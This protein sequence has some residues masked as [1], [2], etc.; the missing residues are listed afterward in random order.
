MKTQY[1]SRGRFGA[2][3]RVTFTTAAREL[4]IDRTT[5]W[6]WYQSGKLSRDDAGRIW[7]AE[8]RKLAAARTHKARAQKELDAEMTRVKETPFPEV[9][10]RAIENAEAQA[11][12]A[13]SEIRKGRLRLDP[14][15]I[16][17]WIPKLEKRIGQ[18]KT[19]ILEF[20]LPA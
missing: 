8:A 3:R 19:A 12:L 5:L 13:G 2:S 18:L 4:N 1:R 11:W 20:N 14:S 16:N 15:F 10:R 17:V 7:I 9:L 6:R